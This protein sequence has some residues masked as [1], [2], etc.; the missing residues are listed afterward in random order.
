[1]KTGDKICYHVWFAT[2]GRKRLLQGQIEGKV[3]QL[4]RIIAGD[5]GIE[6]LVCETMFD[7]VHLLLRSNPKD[8]PRVI[9][10]LKGISARRVFQAFPELKLDA[11]T[12]NLWQARYG[13][14]MIPEETLPSLKRYITTQK[15]RPEKY[16]QA[17]R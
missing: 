8:L 6:L 4:F 16:E 13:A 2:K 12:Q 17:Y 1:M 15:N 10:L 3:K 5:Q 14:K 11:K 7:H 9:F